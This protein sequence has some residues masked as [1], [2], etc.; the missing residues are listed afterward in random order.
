M[1]LKNENLTM[2]NNKKMTMNLTDKFYFGY[3]LL[4]IPITILIDSCIVIPEAYRTGIQDT[5]VKFHILSN[6]DFLVSSPP[7]W[8][9]IAVIF[10]LIFQLP[11]FV[12][13]CYT[14]YFHILENYIWLALYGLN[15]SLTTLFCLYEIYVYGNDVEGFVLTVGDKLGLMGVYLPTFLI[16]LVMLIDFSFRVVSITKRFKHERHSHHHKKNN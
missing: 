2:K 15:A 4:H 14:V 7:A 8:L 3:F 11:I 13:G 16:P 5:I 6:K 9:Q 1:S 12:I 10:E